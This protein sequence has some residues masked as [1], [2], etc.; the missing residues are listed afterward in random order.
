MELNGHDGC[1][2]HGCELSC[3]PLFEG[4][5][6]KGLLFEGLPCGSSV[7]SLIIGIH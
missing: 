7:I 5:C 3:E 2:V 4:P 1:G 6:F